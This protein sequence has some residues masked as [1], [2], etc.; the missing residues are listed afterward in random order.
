MKI[1]LE[2]MTVHPE[3]PD[4]NKLLSVRLDGAPKGSGKVFRDR[5]LHEFESKINLSRPLTLDYVIEFWNKV[6]I[7]PQENS[8]VRYTKTLN[9]YL[10][11]G[12]SDN[13]VE[14][15]FVVGTKTRE[16]RLGPGQS[17]FDLPSLTLPDL[18]PDK[19][20][21]TYFVFILDNYA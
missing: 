6:A 1:D 7:E 16:F 17:L 10:E 8:V 21:F 4:G 12:L 14:F 9:V 20:V 11:N 5:L 18:E 2:E 15:R 19:P 3:N 13:T